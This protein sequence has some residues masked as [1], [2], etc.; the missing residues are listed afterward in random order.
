M[1][2]NLLKA[3][4]NMNKN[5]LEYLD[6]LLPSLRRNMTALTTGYNPIFAFA[7]NF[8]RDF[9]QAYAFGSYKNPAEYGYATA[10]AFFEIATKSD[11]YKEFVNMGGSQGASIIGA[12]RKMID[13]VSKQLEKSRNGKKI[14]SRNA[15]GHFIES[16]EAFNDFVETGPRLTEYNKAYKIAKS[17]GMND[18]KRKIIC[19]KQ[20]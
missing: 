11:R 19:S 3:L 5:Q 15:F 2:A 8:P 7:S 1:D 10:K 12:D 9:V 18:Q 4:S 6:K 20:I 14:I 13:N 17:K 16:I